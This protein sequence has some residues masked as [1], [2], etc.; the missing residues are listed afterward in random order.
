MS[1]GY[2]SNGPVSWY[3]L[4]LLQKHQLT[5]F[6]SRHSRQTTRKDLCRAQLVIFMQPQHYD[7]VRKHYRFEPPA[8]EIW[9]VPDVHEMGEG[10]SSEEELMRASQKKSPL[11][12]LACLP[13]RSQY[14]LC[15]FKPPSQLV[16]PGAGRNVIHKQEAPL[17]RKIPCGEQA[18]L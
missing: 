10:L 16:L 11:P 15:P 4:R 14:I 8:Y 18:Q 3:A 12:A 17:S 9:E 13:L 2:P 1:I 5:P 7:W 6:M